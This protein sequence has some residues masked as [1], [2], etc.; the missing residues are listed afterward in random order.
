LPP[1]LAP[2]G[3]D[4]L[5]VDRAQREL[6]PTIKFT[7]Y[8]SAE[9]LQHKGDKLHFDADSYRELGRRYAATY[10]QLAPGTR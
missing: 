8:V 5:L 10:L 2:W 4:K 9:G 6:P 7:A 3:D 1:L